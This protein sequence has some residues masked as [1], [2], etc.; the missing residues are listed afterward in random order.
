[1]LRAGLTDRLVTGMPIRWPFEDPPDLGVF[2]DRAVADR[3]SPI[4]RVVHERDGEWQFL[5]LEPR[6]EE[7]LP[8]LLCFE[9]ILEMCPS[10]R[11]LNTL[12]R[13]VRAA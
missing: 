2:C 10:I 9:H 11:S 12:P 1:V 5:S 13:L 4:L 7:E 3:T 6:D 8:M